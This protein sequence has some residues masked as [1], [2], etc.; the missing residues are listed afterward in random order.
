MLGFFSQIRAKWRRLQ[1]LL[2]LP[3]EDIS[4]T[5]EHVKGWKRATRAWL[6]SNE[7]QRAYEQSPEY[8]EKWRKISEKLSAN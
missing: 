8:A 5:I 7:E 2:S 4:E 1:F 6:E 3:E